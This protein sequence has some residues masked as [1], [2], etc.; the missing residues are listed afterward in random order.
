MRQ[1]P[2]HSQTFAPSGFRPLRAARN[3]TP[4]RTSGNRI[5]TVYRK[6]DGAPSARDDPHRFGPEWPRDLRDAHPA[7][8][9]AAARTAPRRRG[10]GQ[11]TDCGVRANGFRVHVIIASISEI[12][13]GMHHALV[14]EDERRLA[15]GIQFNLQAE[16]Y[17]VSVASDGNT[18]L[19]IMNDGDPPVDLVILDLMLPGMSG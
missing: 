4:T 1:R 14:V 6:D 7:G 3:R 18:A 17:R 11:R 9:N 19:R 12:V 8:S 10:G 2:R 13:A 5:G 16:G 15:Q